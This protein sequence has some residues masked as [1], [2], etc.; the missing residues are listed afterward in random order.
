MV[1]VAERHR[2]YF[3]PAKVGV[4]IGVAL[5]IRGYPRLPATIATLHVG[6]GKYQAISG[7]GRTT[8]NREVTGSTPVGATFQT[9]GTLLPTI[10]VV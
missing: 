2:V 3:L 9:L 10:Q 1:D 7:I 4:A 5:A 8:E 6:I